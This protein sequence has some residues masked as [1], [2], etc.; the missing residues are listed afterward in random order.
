MVNDPRIDQIAARM[1][2]EVSSGRRLYQTRVATYVRTTHGQDLTRRN[3]NG[4]WALDPGINDAFR[5]LSG[6]QVVWERS[7]QCWRLRKQTDKP[8]RMQS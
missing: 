5:I 6:D 7:T 3:K 4:N 8:G 2:S 1:M